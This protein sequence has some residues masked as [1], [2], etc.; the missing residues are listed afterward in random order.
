MSSLT[1]HPEAFEA[2]KAGL[3]TGTGSSVGLSFLG[4]RI[5]TDPNCPKHPIRWMWDDD[6]F[7][8]YEESDREWCEYFGIGG[9]VREDHTEWAFYQIGSIGSGYWG[10]NA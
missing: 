2:L 6:P 1:C 7:F 9:R 10:L 5:H 3:D 8:E 4:V